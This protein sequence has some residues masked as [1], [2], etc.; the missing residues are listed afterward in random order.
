MKEWG[1]TYK[2]KTRQN[3]NTQ[4]IMN[5]SINHE[6]WWSMKHQYVFIHTTNTV[7]LLTP[8]FPKWC[9]EICPSLP[10]WQFSS[11]LLLLLSRLLVGSLENLLFPWVQLW[12]YR[13]RAVDT[14]NSVS[15]SQCQCPRWWKKGFNIGWP[16]A[17]TNL[18]SFILCKRT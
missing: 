5:E 9:L 15:L 13:T 2:W 6:E 7:S 4:P 11:Q 8:V 17:A 10:Y 3:K 1:L 16:Y 18:S 12:L 14:E